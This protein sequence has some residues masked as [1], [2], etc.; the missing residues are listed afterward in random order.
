MP[1]N[2]TLLLRL[3]PMIFVFLWATGFPAAKFSTVDAEPFTFLA[4][5]F[6]IAAAVLLIYVSLVIRPK[7]IDWRQVY[8]SAIIGVLIQ[9]LYLGGVFFAV[10]KGM[11]AG[12]SS[13]AVT[14]QPFMTAVLAIFV[15]NE[16]LSIVRIICFLFALMGMYLVLFPELD[17]AKAIPGVTTLTLAAVAISPIAISIGTVFQK[18]LVTSI[19]LWVATTAQ[20][21]GAAIAMSL[22]S[23]LFESQRLEWTLNTVLTMAWLVIVLSVGAVGLLM[24]LIRRGNSSS[25]A[26]LFFLVPVVSLFM[27]WVL[28][29]DTMN[30]VQI[31][32]SVIVV[33]SVAVSTKYGISK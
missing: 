2:E 18:R 29:G 16:R 31:F 26:S 5:R 25:V 1:A 4:A 33:L 21:V 15:L 30:S 19:N 32:G 12:I 17:I 24:Y 7:N 13:L 22:L 28:F 27:T 23:Y 3:A 14:L 9:G 6:V 8:Y 20:F 11:P 10:Y